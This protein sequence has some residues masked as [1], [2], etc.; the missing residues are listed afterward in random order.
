MREIAARSEERDTKRGMDGGGK[1]LRFFFK[2]AKSLQTDPNGL[3]LPVPMK[4][5]P[6]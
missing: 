2:I 3:A 5:C 1:M 6:L 4:V